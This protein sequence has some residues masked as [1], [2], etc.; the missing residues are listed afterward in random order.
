MA[1]ATVKVEAAAATTPSPADHPPSSLPA[2]PLL[3]PATAGAQAADESRLTSPTSALRPPA[4]DGGAAADAVAAAAATAAATPTR[5][6]RRGAGGGGGAGPSGR[7]PGAA[8]TT[9][10]A[11]AAAKPR[12][13][14][15]SAK[16]RPV[17]AAAAAPR[18]PPPPPPPTSIVKGSWTPAE[19]ARLRA[20]VAQH[21]EGK[22]AAIVGAF[23]GRIGKQ[24]RERWTH[25]LR[26]GITK[27]A[28]SATEEGALVSAHLAQGN[29]WAGIAALLPGRTCNAVKNHWNATL[30][31]TQRSLAREGVARRG[32]VGAGGAAAAP[33]PPSPHQPGPLEAY[34]R[35]MGPA[36]LAS[37]GRRGG[38]V[39]PPPVGP[40][41]VAA[42][43][44]AA[45][46]VAAA[47]ASPAPRRPGRAGSGATLARPRPRP[48][49]G[50]GGG[51]AAAAAAT[52]GE[53]GEA[54]AVEALLLLPAGGGGGR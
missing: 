7:G 2:T 11:A 48:R 17:T 5:H 39:V 25:E 4:F 40:A 8:T 46:A 27:A 41:A 24:L 14:A 42:A 3:A 43:A 49:G 1:D 45:A 35:S 53:G 19:D 32:G 36:T 20:C 44:A 50:R 30:R 18:P 37:L 16:S 9:T 15:R 12:A 26:P 38:V 28:W 52:A 31:R 10:T 54:G 29:C 21:G 47:P 23:P 51:G 13:R 6:F 34:M 22:W 33:P